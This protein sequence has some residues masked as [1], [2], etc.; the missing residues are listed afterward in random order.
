MNQIIKLK[1]GNSG[2]PYGFLKNVDL[3]YR[4]LYYILYNYN[5]VI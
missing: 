1:K 5:I 2:G 3:I 4:L